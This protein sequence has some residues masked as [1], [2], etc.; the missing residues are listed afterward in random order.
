MLYLTGGNDDYSSGPYTVTFLA[1]VTS[2]PFN[3]SITDDNVLEDDENFSLTI[4]T[5]SLPSNVTVDNPSQATVTI[6]DND[7][8]YISSIMNI[9]IIFHLSLCMLLFVLASINLNES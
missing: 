4:D 3:V 2:V 9:V 7:G 6:V 8:T 5:S 1:G